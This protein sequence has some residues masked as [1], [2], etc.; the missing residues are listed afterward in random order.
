MQSGLFGIVGRFPAKYIT[1]SVSGQALGGVLAA[2]AEIVSL[3]VGASPVRSALV[4]FIMADIFIFIS[5]LAF[6]VLTRSV[7]KTIFILIEHFK[8]VR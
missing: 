7:S 8:L 6:L 1:A 5:V 4:Y 2:V 3:W